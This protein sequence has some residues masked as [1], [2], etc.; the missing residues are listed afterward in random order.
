MMEVME[1]AELDAI[2]RRQMEFEQ[3]RNAE[4]VE[5]QRLDAEAS[6]R[7]QKSSGVSLRRRTGFVSRQSLGKR[8]QPV[9]LPGAILRIFPSLPST[10][11]K[12]QAT[13][14]ILLR[15][16]FRIASSHGYSI[17]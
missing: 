17:V 6:R 5:V 8:L 3:M 10:S 14:L 9:H 1:E 4:L 12:T 11:L 2:Q 13:L 15:R 7:L 16:R